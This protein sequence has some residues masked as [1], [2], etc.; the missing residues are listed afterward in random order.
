MENLERTLDKKSLQ[1]LMIINGR[2]CASRSVLRKTAESCRSDLA[3][4]VKTVGGKFGKGICRMDGN[5][6][7][8]GHLRCY[9]EFVAAGPEHLPDSYCLCSAGWVQKMFGVVAGH[10]V[11]V[12]IVQTIKRGAPD[13][14][15]VVR[16]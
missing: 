1:K 5:T 7:Y 8:W 12:E 10:P 9:C 4:W 16:V 6:I 2:A 13:C 15:F 14:R 11:K 3:N